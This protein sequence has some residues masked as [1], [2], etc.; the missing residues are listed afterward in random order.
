MHFVLL[1][2]TGQW[3]SVSGMWWFEK[4]WLIESYIWMLSHQGVYNILSYLFWFILAWYWLCQILK[5]LY[6]FTSWVYFLEYFFPYFIMR[7]C[8]LLMVMCIPSMQYENKSFF[9]SSLLVCIFFFWRIEIIDTESYLWVLY[10]DFWYL[11]GCRNPLFLIYCSEIIYF[12]CH[13][14]C[15]LIEFSFYC[16]P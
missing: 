12:F 9:K 10:N 3:E 11:G 13:L 14:G 15:G 1:Y 4:E 5:C 7:W 16:F 2:G 8:L 6:L